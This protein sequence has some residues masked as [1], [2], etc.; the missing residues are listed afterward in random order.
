[1][2]SVPYLKKY[3]LEKVVPELIKSRGYKN[4]HQ[5]PNL[6]KI[7]LNSAFKAEAD[8]AHMAEVVKEIIKLSGQKPI[9][10]K[11]SQSVA[12]FKVRAGMPL[13]CVV[14]LRGARMWEFYL[15]LTAVALPMIRD[16]RG[17]SNRLDGRGNYSLGI[18]DH[19]IFPETQ[20]D[21][22]QRANIGMDICIATSA[23]TDDEGRDLLRLLGMPFRRSSAAT[24]EA[25]AETAKA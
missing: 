20:A 24:A 1:M 8:K 11:A 6:K 5:V 22:Q 12:S 9:I 19:T 4:I 18:S 3:Y 7:V 16:F 2:A 25:A 15:R 23:Q 17:V 21:G 14:T 13:G 10:T